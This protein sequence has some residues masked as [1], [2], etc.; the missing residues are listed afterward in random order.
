MNYLILWTKLKSC[1]LLQTNCLES[2]DTPNCPQ[3]VNLTHPLVS[4]LMHVILHYV[5]SSLHSL[6]SL[7]TGSLT[8]SSTWTLIS[9]LALLWGCWH[10]PE[11]LANMVAI[12]YSRWLTIM[13][14]LKQQF[15]ATFHRIAKATQQV[16]TVKSACRVTFRSHPAHHLSAKH[17]IAHWLAAGKQIS[18]TTP[19]DP[20]KH[21]S[22]SN[23]SIDAFGYEQCACL[24][25]YDGEQCNICEADYFQSPLSD[26]CIL[27]M[28]RWSCE[29]TG[30][31]SQFV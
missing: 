18:Y 19:C 22:Y 11:Y 17:V 24:T 27:C 10:S 1:C 4:N 23:C 2:F 31:V 30:Y 5:S 26:Q 8:C 25:G 21:W 9:S 13:L 20:L 14:L 15:M 6:T 16:S 28:L 12:L 3:L 29:H 7:L